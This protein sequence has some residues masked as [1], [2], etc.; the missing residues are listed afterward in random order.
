MVGGRPGEQSHHVWWSFMSLHIN[1][2]R[3]PFK[4]PSCLVCVC[5]CVFL[6]VHRFERGV[7]HFLLHILTFF[8]PPFDFVKESKPS[9]QTFL[10]TLD[11]CLANKKKKK[12]FDFVMSLGTL[13]MTKKE[14]GGLVCLAGC[15]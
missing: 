7:F 3:S 10:A 4:A 14:G 1:L 12:N 13:L 5:V 8:P 15:H 2:Q 6:H 11:E 9:L